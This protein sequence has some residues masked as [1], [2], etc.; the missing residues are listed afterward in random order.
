MPN[1]FGE[2]IRVGGTVVIDCLS[3]LGTGGAEIV[4]AITP[5]EIH[6]GEHRFDR[7]TG[8]ALNPPMAY[9]ITNLEVRGVVGP[10]D[11]TV[12]LFS[13]ENARKLRDQALGDPKGATVGPLLVFVHERIR[14][15]AEDGRSEITRPF[16][17][18]DATYPEFPGEWPRPEV[19]EAVWAALR[20]EGFKVTHHPNPDPGSPTGVAYD[21]VSW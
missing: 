15:A 19:Q 8:H 21:T 17:R 9:Y 6:C 14:R 10:E 1:K 4:T 5:T 16:L 2:P 3:G 13:A 12:P 11:T 7:K 20:L 18:P